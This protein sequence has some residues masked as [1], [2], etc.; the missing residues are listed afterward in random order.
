M[1]GTSRLAGTRA[2]AGAL[3]FAAAISAVAVAHA[4]A[5]RPG[6]AAV[7]AAQ[8]APRTIYL[9]AVEPRGSAAVDQESFPSAELPAGGGYVL[10]PPGEDGRWEV[11]SYRWEPGTVVVQQGDEVTL[12]I[13]GINGREHPSTVEGYDLAFTVQR[14]Q[15]SRVTFTADKA[16]IFNIVC[17]THRPTMTGQLVV[18]PRP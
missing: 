2:R 16:G 14:G 13:L 10:R 5:P 4:Q 15:L 11:S 7:G 3:V 8:P 1:F 17:R 9:A 6:S 12:E 18:L